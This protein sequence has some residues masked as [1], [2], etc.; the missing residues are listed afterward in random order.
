M[1]A[2]CGLHSDMTRGPFEPYVDACLSLYRDANVP[3]FADRATLVFYEMLKERQLF[4]EAAN[5]LVK[6]AGD[7]KHNF[8]ACLLII[9]EV[10]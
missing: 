2:L 6:M 1:I 9:D 8:I 3:H 7:V 10:M 5:F 4:K